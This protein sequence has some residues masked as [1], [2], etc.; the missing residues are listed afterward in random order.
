MTEQVVEL[1]LARAVQRHQ[2]LE[3]ARFV[4]RVMVD[5]HPRKA[6]HALRQEIHQ[7][8][9]RGALGGAI[10]RPDRLEAR[11]PLARHR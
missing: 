4:G 9:E 10:V 5:V 7:R 8:L 2:A 3:R 6:T 11:P 1:R